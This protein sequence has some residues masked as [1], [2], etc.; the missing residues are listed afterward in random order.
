MA[1]ILAIEPE[2]GIRE[3]YAFALGD[4]YE[5][6]TAPDPASA[7]GQCA[8]TAVDAILI[9]PVGRGMS[10]AETIRHAGNLFA[11]ARIMVV[12]AHSAALGAVSCFEAGAHDYMTKP[13]DVHELRMRLDQLLE[14]ACAERRN[15]ASRP[16]AGFEKLTGESEPWV[17]A[18]ALARHAAETGG[19]VL[20]TGEPGTG[21]T[22]VARSVHL[23]STRRGGPLFFVE[24]GKPEQGP[25]LFDPQ[26]GAA[27]ASGGGTLCIENVERLQPA[28]QQQL[29]R[30]IQEGHFRAAGSNAPV[31]LDTR[32]VC[33]TSGDLHSEFL[34]G[35]FPEELFDRISDVT[36]ELPP[37]RVR[38]GDIPKLTTCFT[39]LHAPAALSVATRF[40]PEAL[41]RLERHNWPGNVSELEMAVRLTLFR[42]RD[43]ATIDAQDLDGVLPGP[44]YAPLPEFGGMPL[45]EATDKLEKLII[46]RALE[47]HDYVQSH[48]AEAL[49]TTRRI[50]KYKMDQ[51]GIPSEPRALHDTFQRGG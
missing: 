12:T 38:E 16:R 15:T 35:G 7:T 3:A 5:V 28:G 42:Y 1:T 22:S 24:A 2:S 9:E 6:L 45:Q 40:S 10:G 31:N 4:Q 23:A 20:I 26:R 37:L 27:R 17:N 50:L 30:I 25:P 19:P 14:G 36:V 34:R 32:I 44:G 18:L 8:R 39:A 41:A 51:L 21:K 11:A 49:G 46:T 33:T 29:L 43:K 13:F 47:Q 48:A